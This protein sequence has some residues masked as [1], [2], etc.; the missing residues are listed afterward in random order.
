MTTEEVINILQNIDLQYQ[1][2]CPV[3]RVDCAKQENK[4]LVSEALKYAVDFLST[5]VVE[6]KHGKWIP[7]NRNGLILTELTRQQGVKF[8][9]YKCSNCNYIYHGN[10]LIECSF[11]QN[12]GA[13]MREERK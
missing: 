1:N 7:C 6:L 11:C 10:A 3:S 9:G 5:N 12:C 13:D 2:D 8:Y 4:Y